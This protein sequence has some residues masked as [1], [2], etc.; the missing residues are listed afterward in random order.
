ML[1][2]RSTRINLEFKGLM[3]HTIAII[4]NVMVLYSMFNDQ[5]LAINCCSVTILLL[6]QI[7]CIYVAQKKDLHDLLE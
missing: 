7:S 1:P 2:L 4:V 6:I 5:A 3:A